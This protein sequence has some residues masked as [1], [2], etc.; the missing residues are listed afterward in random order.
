MV[1]DC[2]LNV[3]YFLVVRVGGMDHVFLDL[4]VEDIRLCLPYRE[5]PKCRAELS[6]RQWFDDLPVIFDPH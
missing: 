3:G 5:F 4:I 6:I 2:S 1:C